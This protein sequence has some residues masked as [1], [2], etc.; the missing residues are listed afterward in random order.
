MMVGKRGKSFLFPMQCVRFDM[1][2]MILHMS[3]G[4]R[5]MS[6]ARSRASRTKKET[7]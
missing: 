4:S 7:L 3:W 2:D 1:N 6:C 5:Y